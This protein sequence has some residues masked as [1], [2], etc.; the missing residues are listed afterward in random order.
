MPLSRGRTTLLVMNTTTPADA[1]AQITEH[2]VLPPGEGERYTGFAVLGVPFASG[3]VLA[4]RLIGA[5]SVASGYRSVWHRSPD[6]TW[7]FI[8]TTAA[9]L[10][11]PR[12]FGAE[13]GASHL[14][15]DVV[16]RWPDPWRV[17]VSVPDVL[18]WS[19]TFGDTPAT[20]SMSLVAGHLPEP[21]WSTPTVLAPMG[22]IAGPYLG[23]G[24]ARLHGTVPNGQ[25]FTAAPTRLWAVTESTAVVGSRYL[26]DP[27]PLTEQAWL[28]GFPLPQRG[29]AAAA[30]G[31]FEPFD[32]TRHVSA[33]R[34]GV[35]A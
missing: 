22:R 32:P 35:S 5:L 17:E 27:A 24:Q 23:I 18:E 19:V 12:Y 15:R 16:V 8:T 33:E 11:C 9:H 31:A 13:P 6:G 28:A 7:R 20:R 30:H 21:A 10:S 2:P 1:A 3:D 29:L 4:L 26:G 25:R 14:R 34:R